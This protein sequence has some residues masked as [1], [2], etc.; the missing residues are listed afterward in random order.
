MMRVTQRTMY[1]KM[2]NNM[3]STLGAYMES[4]TQGASQKRINRPS[5][6]PAGAAL[7]LNARRN[8]ENSVQ[9]KANVDTAKGWLQ[10]TDGVLQQTSTTLIKINI[11]R[12][13]EFRVH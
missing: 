5:D 8:I 10:L 7:V 2:L 12:I 11:P 1:T 3:Q 9:Y 6:D 4:N 13:N